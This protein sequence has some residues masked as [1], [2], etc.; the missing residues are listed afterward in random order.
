M[1]G[2]G[3]NVI[4]PQQ[5][6]QVNQNNQNTVNVTVNATTNADPDQIASMTSKKVQESLGQH[7]RSA[8]IN[9]DNSIAR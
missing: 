8:A 6:G 5:L 9:A 3:G 2:F 4:T 1:N 7:F